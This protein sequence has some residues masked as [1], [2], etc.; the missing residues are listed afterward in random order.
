MT[1]V[2]E[3]RDG[4]RAL[5]ASHP[6]IRKLD[7]DGLRGADTLYVERYSYGVDRG[8]GHEARLK[9]QQNLWVHRDAVSLD[10]LKDIKHEV[11]PGYEKG[12]DPGRNSNLEQ[13]PGFRQEPLICFYP[14]TLW[15][16][17]RVIQT[18]PGAGGGHD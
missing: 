18:A 8:I 2:D 4:I 13:I 15:E 12:Q 6:A 10:W 7:E 1:T 17:V 9:T 11:K 14:K 5:L 16:A 3:L